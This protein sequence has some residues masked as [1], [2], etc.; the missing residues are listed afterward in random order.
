MVKKQTIKILHVIEFTSCIFR[1]TPFFC[2]TRP[3]SCVAAQICQ[4]CLKQTSLPCFQERFPV[5]FPERIMLSKAKSLNM[6]KKHRKVRVLK[7]ILVP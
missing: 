5:I 6:W 7:V 1:T 3:F 4:R 2:D